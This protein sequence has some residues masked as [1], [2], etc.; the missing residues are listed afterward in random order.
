VRKTTIQVI[1]T[2]GR[3]P[4]LSNAQMSKVM[5]MAVTGIVAYWG[6]S[7]VLRWEDCVA[8]EAARAIAM[9]QRGFSAGVP[10]VQMY[11]AHAAGGLQH[12][13][14]FAGTLT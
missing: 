7:T 14:P 11:A 13:P 12:A 2:I 3:V 5:S 4:L 8:I 6:R 9:R 10:Y 1:R